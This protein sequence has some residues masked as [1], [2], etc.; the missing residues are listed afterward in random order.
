MS[1]NTAH[2]PVFLIFPPE[3][4][5]PEYKSSEFTATTSDSQNLLQKFLVTKMKIL[6]AIQILLGIMIFSFGV[7]FVF[8]LI[9]PYP[10]FP[11]IFIS[12]YPFWGSAAFIIS[13]A[14]LIALKRKSTKTLLTLS[15]V[16]NIVSA[17]GATAGI[18]L[19][20]FGFL[21]DGHY[22]CGYSRDRPPCEA[23]TILF[24]GS[25]AMLMIFTIVGLAL[26]LAFS[27]WGCYSEEGYE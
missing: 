19:L 3:I 6:G 8:L 11:F 2:S 12:G 4:N 9:K 26:S 7:I 22:I 13:G 18:I 25:L 15:R 17:V 5:S 27:I 23:I 1:S 16:V 14:F 24:T 20:V 10:R 21:L